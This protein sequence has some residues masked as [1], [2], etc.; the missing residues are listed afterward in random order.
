MRLP[1]AGPGVGDRYGR[2]HDM[3]RDNDCGNFTLEEHAEKAETEVEEK[4]NKNM[5]DGKREVLDLRGERSTR[6]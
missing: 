2:I 5:E 6:V 3:D 1:P 4:T